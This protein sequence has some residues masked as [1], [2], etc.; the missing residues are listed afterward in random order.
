MISKEEMSYSFL[1]TCLE[2]SYSVHFDGGGC[3]CIERVD[4]ASLGDPDNLIGGVKN[5]SAHRSVFATDDE[6]DFRI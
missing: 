3:R 2:I 5:V 4:V 6:E 1:E